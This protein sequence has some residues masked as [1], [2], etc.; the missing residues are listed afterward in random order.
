LN[1]VL[2]NSSSRINRKKMMKRNCIFLGITISVSLLCPAH[3]QSTQSLS[4]SNAEYFIDTI[5]Y[6]LV[7]SLPDGQYMVY[8]D[9]LKQN[10]FF[11]GNIVNNVK[12]GIWTWYYNTGIKQKEV[13]Y[14]S[15]VEHGSYISYYPN[16]QMSLSMIFNMGFKDGLITKWYSSGVKSLEGITSMNTPRGIWN[17]WDEN[18]VLIS[19]T[20]YSE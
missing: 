7:E 2:F 11:K 13:Q 14:L 8:Y 4:I 20:K 6:N 9:T 17:K 15:G 12:D 18:G 1:K 3:S 16:G 19:S 10:L 5:S